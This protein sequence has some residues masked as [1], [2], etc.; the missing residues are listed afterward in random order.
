MDIIIT[1]RMDLNEKLI[2][3][4]IQNALNRNISYI[5]INFAKYDS[6]TM[7]NYVKEILEKIN[8]YFPRIKIMIDL[9]YPRKKLD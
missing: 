4:Q 3:H 7:M 2:F 6:E 9:P 8:E 1:L 5:R